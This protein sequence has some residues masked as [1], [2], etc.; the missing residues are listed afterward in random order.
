MTN[1]VLL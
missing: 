1:M